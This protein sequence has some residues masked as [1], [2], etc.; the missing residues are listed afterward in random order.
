M[1]STHSRISN[2]DK[3]KLCFLFYCGFFFGANWCQV[4]IRF[5]FSNFSRK[6]SAHSQPLSILLLTHSCFFHPRDSNSSSVW[7]PS[8]INFQDFSVISSSDSD[9]DASLLHFHPRDLRSNFS[10]IS[11]PSI[12]YTMIV[13]KIFLLPLLS[14]ALRHRGIWDPHAPGAVV[15]RA[16]DVAVTG[17]DDPT[18]ALAILLGLGLGCPGDRRRHRDGGRGGVQT[19]LEAGPDGL[20]GGHVAGLNDG[21]EGGDFSRVQVHCCCYLVVVTAEGPGAAPRAGSLIFWA[22]KKCFR[23]RF[24]GALD[25]PKRVVRD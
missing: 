8:K 7:T 11:S 24:P 13:L 21:V 16:L 18:A 25:L 15:R 12:L 20:D 19:A 6:L 9:F 5:K 17:L 4:F 2:I 22:Q 3:I 10:F 1:I 14:L 23:L